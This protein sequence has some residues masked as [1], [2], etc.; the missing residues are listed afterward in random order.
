MDATRRCLLFRVKEIGGSA[1]PSK[2]TTLS[3]KLHRSVLKDTHPTISTRETYG[4]DM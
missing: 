2:T 3:V 4:E 1:S